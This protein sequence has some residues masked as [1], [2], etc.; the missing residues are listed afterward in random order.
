[1]LSS[2]A[3]DNISRSASADSIIVWTAE[4]DRAKRERICNVTAMDIYDIKMKRCEFY[5]STL[6]SIHNWLQF[7]LVQKYFLN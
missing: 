5:H 3:F 6:F 1:M 4:E 7:P 2:T